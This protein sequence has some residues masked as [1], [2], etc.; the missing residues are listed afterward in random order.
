MSKFC[1][2]GAL[3][4]NVQELLFYKFIVLLRPEMRHSLKRILGKEV[5][6][7]D[8][9]FDNK[10]VVV[11]GAAAGV[12]K[13]IVKGFLESGAKV[14]LVDYNEQ[15]LNSTY[16]GLAVSYKD[17]IAMFAADLRQAASVS[18]NIVAYAEEKLG[19][20]RIL[21][22]NAGIYP[23]KFA[24]EITEND[25]DALYDLN[26]KGYFF[27]AQAVAKRMV[28]QGMK[29]SIINISSTASI[30][31]RPGV[32]HYCSSKAAIKMM[33]QV[34]ALEWAQYRIRVNAVAPGLIET[35]ALLTS[36]DSDVAQKEH[37]EKISMCPLNRVGLPSEIAD[38]VLFLA[39][40]NAAYIT[41]QNLFADGG[42][43]AGRVF[44]SKL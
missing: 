11:T 38:S 23:S 27:M 22:N 24:L 41:G 21:V 36:L 5:F 42:Y 33:T 30:L 14:L 20:I 2:N 13:G 31:A 28:D 34:L 10:T 25:W 19:P 7:M 15:L 4:E 12:G 26:V 8:I 29:G 17:N 43:T 9:R 1:G 44:K 3:I 37:A 39:S 35:E 6:Y 32:A 16:S 18:A 40:D